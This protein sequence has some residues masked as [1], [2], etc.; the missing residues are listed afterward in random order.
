MATQFIHVKIGNVDG[1][2]PVR[3]LIADGPMHD[4]YEYQKDACTIA[5]VH[6]Q[7]C[8]SCLAD[9]KPLTQDGRVSGDTIAA[10]SQD[11]DW[12]KFLHDHWDTERNHCQVEYLEEFMAIF[13]RAAAAYMNKK[14]VPKPEQA[15]QVEAP[16]VYAEAVPQ[17]TP[18]P[19]KPHYVQ[20]SL[21][22]DL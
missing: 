15:A 20:L 5:W 7:W 1:V 12:R 16:V 13:R 8:T 4:M 9:G 19:K 22:P 18:K 14:Q 21:F 3:E 10:D 2:Y 11:T 6:R 17:P